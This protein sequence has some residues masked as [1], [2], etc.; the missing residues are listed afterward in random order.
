MRKV[1]V[2]LCFIA[3]AIALPA[4]AQM[5]PKSMGEIYVIKTKPSMSMQWEAGAK[6]LIEWSHQQNRPATYYYWSI[7]PGPRT[8]QYVLGT[9]GHDWK[10]FDAINDRNPDAGKIIQEDMDPYT[11]SVRTSFWAYQED[12][13]GP[14]ANAGQAPPAFSAVITFFFKP[15]SDMGSIADMLKQVRAAM[16]KS[17]WPGNPGYWYQRVNGGYGTALAVSIGHPNWAGFQPPDP[18][19]G[20]MLSE[21]YGQA[22]AEAL[23]RKFYGATRAIRS[24]IWAYRPDLSYIAA[25]H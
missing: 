23:F 15:A 14:P 8:G 21:V 19:L 1:L 25:S 20:K 6:K 16:E 3:L 7:I 4:S 22:G 10:D 24:E 17:H 18:S 2:S 13:N 12:I 11:E 9:F 5:A